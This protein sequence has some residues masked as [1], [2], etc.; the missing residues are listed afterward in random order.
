MYEVSALYSYA[1]KSFKGRLISEM[2][3]DAFG[4]R[5]DRRFMLVDAQ[6][7]HVTQRC[8]PMMA[9]LEAVVCNDVLELSAGDWSCSLPLSAFSTPVSTKVWSDIVEGLGCVEPEVNTVLTRV[10]SKEVRLVLMPDTSYRAVD[11]AF[12]RREGRVSYADGFP[13]LICNEASLS[14][15]NARLDSPVGMTRFRPNIVVRGAK[16]YAES[17]WKRIRI[18]AVEFD[19]VK[20]CSRCSMITLDSKGVFNKEPLKTLATYRRNEFGVCFGENAMHDGRDGLISIGD[21]V[22]VLE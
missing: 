17:D 2:P 8:T 5:F 11:Q 20:P 12:A 18:G 19:L 15:L 9:A 3:L 14:D 22:E 13:F 6:G 16:A 1:V 21:V 4:P 10:L 7:S